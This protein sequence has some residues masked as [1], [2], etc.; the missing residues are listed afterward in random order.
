MTTNTD[1]RPPIDR[2]PLIDAYRRGYQQGR[3]DGEFVA[4]RSKRDHPYD[5]GCS[6]ADCQREAEADD[7]TWD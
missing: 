4:A 2:D 7:A 5:S 3:D 1:P 6:C